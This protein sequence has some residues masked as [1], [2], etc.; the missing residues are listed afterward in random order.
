M[1]SFTR[2]GRPCA[3][4]C[5]SAPSGRTCTA[6][7]VG[8]KSATRPILLRT[9]V[10][11][12][13]FRASAQKTSPSRRRPAGPAPDPQASPSRAP[14]GTG[15]SFGHGV[16]LR[17]RRRRQRAAERTRPAAPAAPAG[18]RLHLRGRRAHDPRRPP[19][20]AEPRARVQRRDLAVD[21]AGD[22][23]DR[24][25]ALLGAPRH[26]HPRHGPRALGGH[27][28]PGRRPGRLDDHAAVRQE[29]ADGQRADGHAQ[30]E[31]GGA[32]VAAR[33]GLDEGPDPHRL[34]QHHLL[35]ERRVRRRA[36][37]ADVLRPQRGEAEPARGGAARRHPGG[38]EPVRPG[39]APADG[40]GAPD[41]RPAAD[42]AAARDQRGAVP[43]GGA[44]ADA[45]AAERPPLRR[46]GRRAVLRRVR[47]VAADLEPEPR[48]EEGLRRRL[49]RLHDDQPR[50]AEAR[51]D[52]DPQVA[53]RSERAAGGAR[54][55]Q[56]DHRRRARHV[57]RQQLP[58]EPVQ[59]RRAG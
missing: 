59:P 5:S 33:A 2:S 7:R 26:R 4:F 36:R 17:P 35:R 49:P 15:R 9:P 45:E 44:A 21:Q 29:L 6:C 42:A 58:R 28:A 43:L 14:R 53:A 24:G 8:A 52:G 10:E 31:G 51:A 25:Q 46:A 37:G 47:Q 57:R 56:P 19:R 13:L 48:R 50:A 38:P 16:L 39:R 41:D 55:A 40:E 11:S 1:P 30:A 18:R 23:R 27:P 32:R 20:L 54:R 34:P 22:R 3:S 12:R